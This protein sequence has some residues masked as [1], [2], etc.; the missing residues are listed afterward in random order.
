[1]LPL[2][3]RWSRYL[4]LPKAPLFPTSQAAGMGRKDHCLTLELQGVTELIPALIQLQFPE[5]FLPASHTL[6]LPDTFSGN[7]LLV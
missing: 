4:W 6:V 3:Q 1:M 5:A 2:V 7:N